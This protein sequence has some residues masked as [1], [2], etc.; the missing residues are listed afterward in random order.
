VR[1]AVEFGSPLGRLEWLLPDA[2]LAP[3]REALAAEAGAKTAP[4]APKH[5]PWAPRIARSLQGAQLELRA[6]LS[7][8]EISL[9]RLVR[10]APGDIIPIEA[11]NE[12]TLLVGD[13]ALWRG[14][15]GVS[16]GHNALK[17][18]PGDSTR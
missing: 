6:V 2:M 12:V 8:V 17:I 9:G 3:V 16:Q 15:F 13:V 18:I 11:P 10:L 5:E 4:S 7:E 1:F 14:R